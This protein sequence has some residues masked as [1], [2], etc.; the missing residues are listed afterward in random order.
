M[1]CFFGIFVVYFFVKYRGFANFINKIISFPLYL[2]FPLISKRR[3]WK[4]VDLNFSRKNL[5]KISIF[6]FLINS[7]LIFAMFVPFGISEKFPEYRMTSVY[8]GQIISFFSTFL[9]FGLLDPNIMT[10]VS[11]GDVYKAIQNQVF[12]RFISYVM[13]SA[14]FMIIGVFL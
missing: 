13:M 3:I 5:N 9:T 11:R 7:F 14:I 2:S 10:S 1:S 8:I 12:G 4:S 6:S